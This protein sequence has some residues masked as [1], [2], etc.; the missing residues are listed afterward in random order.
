MYASSANHAVRSKTTVNKISNKITRII[1]T[2]LC[3]KTEI[4]VINIDI[5]EN[6]IILL[7]KVQL[8]KTNYVRS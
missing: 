5:V 3:F 2:L 7:P 8:I 1:K 6:R 4:V